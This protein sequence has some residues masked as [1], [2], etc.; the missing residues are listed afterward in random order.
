MAEISKLQDITILIVLFKQ[1][2]AFLNNKYIYCYIPSSMPRLLYASTPTSAI[3]IKPSYM[4]LDSP[5]RA[6]GLLLTDIS[7]N[8]ASLFFVDY[9]S[10]F[11]LSN[12]L[13]CV[14]CVL[15]LF[16]S[17]VVRYLRCQCISKQYFAMSFFALIYFYIKV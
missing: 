5:I 17:N 12:A 6:G 1:T 16:Y 11:Q 3:G 7:C 2:K 4:L 13:N 10:F 14:C 15:C 8:C 9:S